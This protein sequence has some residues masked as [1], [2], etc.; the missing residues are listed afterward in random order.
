MADARLLVDRLETPVGTLRL[1]VTPAGALRQ[2]GW[3]DEREAPKGFE[4]VGARDP[5]GVSTAL[6]EYFAGK[7]ETIDTLAVDGQGTDFQRRVWRAL[8][9]VP[10]GSTASYGNIAVRIGSPRAFRAVGAANHDNPI[11]IVV[12]C[13]RIIGKNGAL[14]GY[15]GGLERKRWLLSHEARHARGA[16]GE[17]LELGTRPPLTP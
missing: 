10:A 8:R 16:C 4:L 3:F 9:E 5:F 12:P 14:T 15:A 11:G 2:L 13:H 1:L 6:A 7:V 17:Q